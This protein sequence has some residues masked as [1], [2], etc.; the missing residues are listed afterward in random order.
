MLQLTNIVEKTDAIYSTLTLPFELRQKSR[1]RTELDNGEEVMFVLPRGIILRDAFLLQ[2]QD[3]QYTVEIKA[4][5]ETVSNIEHSDPLLLMRAAYH[6]GN[7]HVPVQISSGW[8][9]YEH[10]HVLDHMLEKLHL[11]ID[12]IQAPFEPEGGAY[13]HSHHHSH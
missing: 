11:S 13:G 8:I 2:T 10:D 7:R 4:A 1:L 12:V 6:L 9:R 5:H 3:K